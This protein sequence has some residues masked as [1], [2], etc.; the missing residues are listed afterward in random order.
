MET[1]SEAAGVARW[2]GL[3]EL[4][5]MLR[6]YLG[7]RCRDESELEDVLQETLLRAARYR[8][9]LAESGRLAHWA[10]R[11][12]GNV[13]RDHVRRHRCAELSDPGLEGLA[14]RERPP[15]FEPE[16]QL[17]WGT[18]VVAQ[19]TA[20]QHMG[21]A[22][23][24]LKLDDR[25]VLRSYYGGGQSCARTAQEC[26]LPLGLVKVRLF[27]ARR[28]L[29]R[30]LRQRLRMH[31]ADLERSASEGRGSTS[32]SRRRVAGSRLPDRNG[33]VR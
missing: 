3:S 28:R 33:T 2:G 10:T 11:I 30:A 26:E 21:I 9:A 18:M 6:R 12:A 25:R 23:E 4:E 32:R 7:R 1:G 13:L 19:G 27:R 17:R 8:A 31:G 14:S 24:G 15:G 22:L 5:P 29:A 16:P 20:L